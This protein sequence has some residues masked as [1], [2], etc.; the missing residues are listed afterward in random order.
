MFLGKIFMNMKTKSY[1][2]VINF[3]FLFFNFFFF[4]VTF[5]FSISITMNWLR[6]E[7]KPLKHLIILYTRFSYQIKNVIR[8]LKLELPNL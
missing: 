4:L 5:P 1:V 2:T 3:A 7:V 6:C 8:M